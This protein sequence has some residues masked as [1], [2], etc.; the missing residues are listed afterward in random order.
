MENIKEEAPAFPE[1]SILIKIKDDWIDVFKQE[2]ELSAR[3]D[4]IYITVQGNWRIGE[5]RDLVEYVF[6]VRHDQIIGVYT[7]IRW[8]KSNRQPNR[9]RFTGDKASDIWDKYVGKAVPAQ[10]SAKTARCP[11]RYTF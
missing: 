8:K 11:I 9:W 10:Y 3:N 4:M 2:Q 7:N 1:K 6:A 5:K